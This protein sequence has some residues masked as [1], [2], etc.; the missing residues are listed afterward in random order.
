[1]PDGFCVQVGEYGA[2]LDSSV[3]PD[4]MVFPRTRVQPGLARHRGQIR[5]ATKILRRIKQFLGQNRFI[6]VAIRFIALHIKQGV[7]KIAIIDSLASHDSSIIESLFI[8]SP[9]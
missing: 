2:G 1:M 6:L 4:Q 9:L 8:P 7:L 5:V 3:R